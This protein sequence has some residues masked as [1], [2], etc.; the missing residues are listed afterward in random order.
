MQTEK[1]MTYSKKAMEEF[2]GYLKS[3]EP[4]RILKDYVP[5]RKIK[6][7]KYVK[8]YVFF[9]VTTS[10]PSTADRLNPPPKKN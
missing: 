10:K 1:I 5:A 3:K 7:K 9:F 4:I 8:I 6:T 2:L